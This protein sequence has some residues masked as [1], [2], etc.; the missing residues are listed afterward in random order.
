MT[1]AEKVAANQAFSGIARLDF[2]F[3]ARAQMPHFTP[4]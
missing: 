4:T 1:P 3:A 2:V